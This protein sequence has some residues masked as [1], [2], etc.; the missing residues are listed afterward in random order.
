M[1]QVKRKLSLCIIC[2]NKHM[3]RLDKTCY[4]YTVRNNMLYLCVVKY[5]QDDQ[6]L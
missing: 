4:Y 5:N 3:L 6:Q 2:V 1:I